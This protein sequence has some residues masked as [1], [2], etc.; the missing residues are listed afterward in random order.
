M[1][2]RKPILIT[3][4]VLLVYC[5]SAQTKLAVP[6]TTV[7]FSDLGTK[8]RKGKLKEFR[9][10]NSLKKRKVRGLKRTIK[11]NTNL[12]KERL[13]QYGLV[14]EGLDTTSINQLQHSVNQLAEPQM[15]VNLSDENFAWEELK[16]NYPINQQVNARSSEILDGKKESILSEGKTE[17]PDHVKLDSTYGSIGNS[18]IN[19]D[20]YQIEKEHLAKSFR[21]NGLGVDSTFVAPDTLLVFPTD[22][23]VASR[24]E[25]HLESFVDKQVASQSI[26]ES[27][28]ETPA[29]PRNQVKQYIPNLEKFNYEKPTIPKEKLDDAVVQQYKERKVDE[30]KK[31]LAINDSEEFESRQTGLS[32]FEIGGYARYDAS[33]ESIELTPTI[34]YSLNKRINLG[35]GYQT[36][37]SLTGSDSL[38]TK[39]I[40]AFTEYIFLDTYFVHL[41]SEWI[42]RTALSEP[43]SALKERNTYV[44]IGKLFQYKF[45]R[46]SV[47]ALYNFNAPSQLRT[48]KFSVRIG[49]SISK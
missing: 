48:K 19:P 26:F 22:S 35:L 38:N 10:Y 1:A 21:K 44:G 41:E 46:T 33:R 7:Q 29:D 15:M 8:T 47:M 14:F 27:F 20:K 43:E 6:S 36:N 11:K 3:F 24:I 49:L 45:F 13:Q 34:T 4:F 16:S 39:G 31:E 2:G 25:N 18:S 17:I 5:L 23:L 30:L 9:K 37:I 42:K 40:R 12:D 28:D 32:R